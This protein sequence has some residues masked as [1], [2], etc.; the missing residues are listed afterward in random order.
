M[1]RLK[2]FWFPPESEGAIL[3]DV[4]FSPSAYG[5]LS[6]MFLKFNFLVWIQ[7]LKLNL[8]VIEFRIEVL[9]PCEFQV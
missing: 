1:E 4:V 6:W 9:P 8:E 5:Q 7:N 2:S 3:R